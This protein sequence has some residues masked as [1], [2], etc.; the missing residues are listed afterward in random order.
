MS[1]I[2][3][4]LLGNF[5]F[6][7]RQFNFIISVAICIFIP[8]NILEVLFWHTAKITWKQVST[9]ESLF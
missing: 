8:I 9:F 7:T 4:L 3:L 5:L 2:A 6:D 1:Y